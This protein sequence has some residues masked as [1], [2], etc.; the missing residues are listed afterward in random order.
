MNEIA[1]RVENLS[2]QYHIGQLHQRHDTLR[3]ALSAGLGRLRRNSQPKTGDEDDTI[4]ALKDVSFEVKRG[5]VVGIIGRNGAGKSTLLKILTRIT[6]PTRGRAELHGRVG[7]LL[8]VGTGFHP[9]LTGRENIYLSG[10]ILGMKKTE[11]DRRFDEIVAFS[12]VEKFIDTPVKRYSS[13][14]NVR[15]GFAVAAH[16][17]PEILL[18]D[19]VLAVGDVAFQKKCIGKMRSIAG[20]GRTVVLVSH[21]MI[22]IQSLCKRGLLVDRGVIRF[23]GAS[24]EVIQQYLQVEV[25]RGKAVFGPDTM[26]KGDGRARYTD[27]TVLDKMGHTVDSIGVGD[28]CAIELR[29][30][31]NELI[32]NPSFGIVI[33]NSHGQLLAKLTTRITHGVM[34]DVTRDGSVLIHVKRFDVLPGLYYLTFGIS[35]FREQ[36][37]LIEN[38][39][40]VE[41]TPKDVYQTGKLPLPGTAMIYVP[42]HWEHNY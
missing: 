10:T 22:A 3:D 16:L 12:G 2:K 4:W 35:T 5:E 41:V 14:M 29:F 31:A 34:P 32:Q 6:E 9:E 23:D 21:N 1:I 24:T 13:G 18:V 27:A 33:R 38:A 36:I 30:Q 11:I 25:Q 8:E 20:E 42:C 15:L 26:R 17:E 40:V 39:L 28:S 19:E 7:S 37:D